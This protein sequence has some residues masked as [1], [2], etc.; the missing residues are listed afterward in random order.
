MEELLEKYPAKR[1]IMDAGLHAMS[2]RRVAKECGILGVECV[3]VS[4]VGALRFSCAD[5]NLLSDG[6][7]R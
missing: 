4:V 5:G 2:R 6:A 1:V 3:D 7:G